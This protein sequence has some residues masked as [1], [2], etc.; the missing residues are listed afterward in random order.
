MPSLSQYSVVVPAAG[1]GKRMKTDCPKQYLHIAGKTIIEHTLTNLLE[2]S[3]VQRVI[4]VLNPNDTLFAQLPI[5][6]HPRIEVV[7]GGQERCD[8]VLAGLNYLSD[9]EEWVLV[10]DAARPCFAA[11]DLSTLLQLAEQGSIGG[12]LATPVR[13]TMKRAFDVN[14]NRQNIVKHTE[15]REHLWHALT[16]QFFKLA[17]LKKALNTAAEQKINITDEASAIELLGE[18]VLLV[19]G[20]ASNI[21]I[22]QPEDLLLAEFYLTQNKLNN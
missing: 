21:K 12:I 3:Q 19:E 9:N 17:A 18:K 1:I 8:S 15:S 20:S 2:H 6:S 4:L 16:P 7:E 13:D 5:A 22:T 14:V 10:H 11:T